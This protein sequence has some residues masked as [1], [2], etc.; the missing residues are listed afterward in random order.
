MRKAQWQVFKK[1]AKRLNAGPIPLALII[2]SPW[3]PGYR[4]ISHLDYYLDPEVWFNSNLSIMEEFP[5]VIFFPSWWV[6]Y[7]MA[8]EPS[9]F[10]TRL[11]FW[12]DQPPGQTP[13]LFRC[14][15]IERFESANRWRCQ[16]ARPRGD[17]RV[18]RSQPRQDSL[19]A[20]L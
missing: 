17:K 10:G 2:D 15:D 1:A 16:P 4:G 6:E 20:G 11:H 9:A 14:G 19:D 12:R 13:V 3:I 7:G 8:A 5:E 18:V